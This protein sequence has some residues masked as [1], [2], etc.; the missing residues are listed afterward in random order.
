MDW[1]HTRLKPYSHQ[2]NAETNAKAMCNNSMT[3][4][5]RSIA[6]AFGVDALCYAIYWKIEEIKSGISVNLSQE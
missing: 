1:L 3:S 4:Q 6:H 5:S 2:A